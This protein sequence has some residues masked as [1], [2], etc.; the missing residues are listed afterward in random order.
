MGWGWGWMDKFA[1]VVAARWRLMGG[2]ER[3][4]QATHGEPRDTRG[5]AG[6]AWDRGD[7]PG[8]GGGE[9]GGEGGIS[10]VQD[11]PGTAGG[12]RW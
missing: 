11:T 3:P 5:H 8:R 6:Y 12:F 1:A 10:A 7:T 4:F 2:L 9:G